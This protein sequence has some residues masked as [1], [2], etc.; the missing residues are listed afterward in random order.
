MLFNIFQ[1]RHPRCV[2]YDQ[3]MWYKIIQLYTTPNLLEVLIV[4][5]EIQLYNFIPHILLFPM[6]NVLYS[7]FS[8]FP[9]MFAVS[10]RLCLVVP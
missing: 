10:S 5:M 7:Y 3:Y 1:V 6:Q 2:L 8:T 4:F 9:S